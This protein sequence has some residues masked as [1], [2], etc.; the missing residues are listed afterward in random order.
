MDDWDVEILLCAQSGKRTHS[1]WALEH[2]MHAAQPRS[3]RPEPWRCGPA[4]TKA[5]FT[6]KAIIY[7][8]LQLQLA[9]GTSRAAAVKA[10]EGLRSAMGPTSTADKKQLSLP[11]LSK[12][13]GETE[14]SPMEFQPAMWERKDKTFS[15]IGGRNPVRRGKRKAPASGLDT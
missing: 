5:M 8:V 9:D 11:Q 3:I 10:V 12:R 13:L 6:R 4:M 15:N 2:R 7:H 1:F 14:H